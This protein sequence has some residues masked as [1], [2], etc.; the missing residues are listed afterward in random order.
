MHH[1]IDAPKRS[2]SLVIIA[3]RDAEEPRA[4]VG[5]SLGPLPWLPLGGPGGRGSEV[6]IGARGQRSYFPDAVRGV[7]IRKRPS[8]K[9]R[10]SQLAYT[11]LVLFSWGWLLSFSAKKGNRSMRLLQYR[12]ALRE[13]LPLGTQLSHFFRTFW[14]VAIRLFVNSATTLKNSRG[15]LI[16]ASL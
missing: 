14:K 15:D 9:L 7:R 8:S 3:P 13:H 16:V 5:R 1:R 2:V 4:P 10:Q 6:I 11:S 12:E